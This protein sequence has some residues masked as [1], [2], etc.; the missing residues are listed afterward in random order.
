VN[1]AVDAISM[2]QWG[3]SP[4][5]IPIYQRGAWYEN[6]TVLEVAG[7]KFHHTFAVQIWA[8]PYTDDVV[9]YSINS[10]S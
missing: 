10:G 8:F 7:L 1:L 2:G 4:Q 6:A 3:E 9:L 5:P